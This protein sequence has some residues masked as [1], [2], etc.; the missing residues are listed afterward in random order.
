MGDTTLRVSKRLIPPLRRERFYPFAAAL[1]AAIPPF[2]WDWSIGGDQALL[3]SAS[4]TFGA[5]TSGF[6]GTTLGI[7]TSLS[8]KVMHRI[9][10]TRYLLVLREYMGWGLFSGIGV[11]CVSMAGMLLRLTELVWYAALWCAAVVLCLACLYRLSRL[12]LQV[13]SDHENLP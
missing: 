1:L 6:V 2:V 12:M 8:T 10:K 7:L 13:F 9:R 11:C 3:L 5:I 4:I